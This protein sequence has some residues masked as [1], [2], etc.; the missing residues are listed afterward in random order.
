MMAASR[1]GREKMS[2]ITNRLVKKTEAWPSLD[3]IQTPYQFGKKIGYFTF[4]IEEPVD[5]GALL[6]IRT[7]LLNIILASRNKIRVM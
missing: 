1:E 2:T 3:D 4:G 5:K 7:R 6:S